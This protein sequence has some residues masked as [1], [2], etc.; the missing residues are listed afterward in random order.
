MLEIAEVDKTVEKYKNP[1][2]THWAKYKEELSNNI[3]QVK[4]VI[5][6]ELDIEAAWEQLQEAIIT[7]YKASS[8]KTELFQTSQLATRGT[9]TTE[10]AS[11]QISQQSEKTKEWSAYRDSLTAYNRH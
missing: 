8:D 5:K 7:S 6:D 10:A 9:V 3:E 1:R 4:T 2:R 11:T